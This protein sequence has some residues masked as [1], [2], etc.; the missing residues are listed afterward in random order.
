MDTNQSRRHFIKGVTWATAGAFAVPSIVP[1][2]V[3]GKNAPSN[4][5]NIGMIG[6]GRQGIKKNLAQFLEIDRCRVIAV[7]D[8]DHWRMEQAAKIINA[9]YGSA[10]ET[11]Y[12]GVT[13]YYDYRRL[14]ENQDIDAVMISSPDHWHVPQGIAS[15]MARK[16]VSTE[17]ALTICINHSQAFTDAVAHY[18]VSH[19]V[20]S[21]FRSIPEFSKV[22]GL[23]R[24]NVIGAV[25]NVVVGVP[26]PLNGSAPEPQPTMKVPEELDYDMWLG[27]AFPAPYTMRRVHESKTYDVRPGWMRIDDYCNGM[28]TN[29]G[30]HLID[31]ALWGIDKELEP[32]VSV[33]GTGRFTQ[34]LWNTIESFDLTYMFKD[35]TRLEYII[36]SPYVRFE[37]EKGWIKVPFKGAIEASDKSLLNENYEDK[38]KNLPSDKDDFI[39]AI[40]ENKPSLEPLE[41]G[42]N[43]YRLTNM[44]LIAVKLGRKLEWDAENNHFVNDNAA[45][46]MLA[47]PVRAKYID[48]P[49]MDWM[50]KYSY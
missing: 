13:S 46:A 44:G 22:V 37:G 1:S 34:S 4:R 40:L 14:L 11:G 28:I 27:P 49:V 26:A 5:I 21:E 31:I 10:S 35:G 29:W 16:H 33:E 8:P 41:V 39:D 30:A 20:D 25:K 23:V 43:V 32:P 3:L 45:D 12:K 47:R 6:T 48:Q 15:A 17:K 9:H 19:R 42:H 24:N 18:N 50:N 2:S 36:D 38:Y 7:N